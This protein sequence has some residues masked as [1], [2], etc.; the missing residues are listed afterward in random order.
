M[1]QSVSTPYY[2]FKYL[3]VNEGLISN[4][5]NYT[6]K[7]SRGFLWIGTDRGVQRYNGSSFLT[8]RHLHKDSTSLPD[9]NVYFIM[10]DHHHD[11]WMGTLKGISKFSYKNGRFSNYLYAL[12]GKV[13]APINDMFWLLEDSQGRLWAGAR[14]GLYLFDSNKNQFVNIPPVNIPGMNDDHFIRVGCIK[15]TQKQELV[16]T[17]VDG[18]VIMDKQGKQQYFPVPEP[19]AKPINHLP[20][21]Q[22]Y[23]LKDYPDEVWVG[24]NLNGLFKYQRNTKQWTNYRSGGVQNND[25]IYGCLEWDKDTWL[26]GGDF[27]CYFNHRT[28]KFFNGF[29]REKIKY[30]H[31]FCREAN[32]DIWFPS[33]GKGLALFSPSTQLFAKTQMI[34]GFYPDKIFYFDKDLQALYGMNIYFSSGI[35]KLQLSNNVVSRDSIVRFKP[36][37]NVLNN[38]MAANDILYLAMEKGFWQYNLRNQRLDSIVL[39]HEGFSSQQAFFFNTCKSDNKVY[40]TGRF[41][42]GG[43]FVYN[44]ETRAF[45]DL[46][47]PTSQNELSNTYQYQ[48]AYSPTPTTAHGHIN[49]K[50]LHLVYGKSNEPPLYSYSVTINDA[51][52]YVGMNTADSLYTYN[53][54]T[55]HK[56]AIAFPNKY[57]N[58]KPCSVLSLCVDKYQH[59]WCGTSGN[60]VLVYNIATGKWIKQIT[61][62]DGYFPTLTSQI[63]SDE[64]GNIWCNTTEG[65]FLFNTQ[66]FRFKRYGIGEGLVSE[67]SSGILQVLPGHQLLFNNVDKNPYLHTFGIINT[68]PADTI[69]QK[70]PISIANLKVL[71][72]P[73]LTDTLLDNVQHITLP[74]LHNSFSLNYAGVSLPEGKNLLYSYQLE[75]AEKQWHQ[76][77]TEHALSYINLTPGGYTLRI[78]CNN[79]NQSIQG[80]ERILLISILPAWYQTWWFR[81]LVMAIA[82]GFL[83]A[84][85]RY[86]L[87]QQLRKQQIIL[88]KE[89][90][91]EAERQR[92]AADMHDDIG[93]GLSRI[94]YITAAMKE[95]KQMSHEEMDRILSLSDESVEKMNEII[96][97]L[98]QGNRSLE[99]TLA[100]L[101]SQCAE[102]VL[103]SNIE[104]VSHMPEVIPATVLSWTQTRNIYLLAKEAVNNAVKHAAATSIQLYVEIANNQLQLTI[105]DN[106]KGFDHAALHNGNGL[107]G[108][109]K[110]VQTLKGSFEIKASQPTGTIVVFNIPL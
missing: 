101:R 88:E 60:G 41:G 31:S 1:A 47:L 18:F 12:K 81:L 84:S 89:L 13:H 77:G 37:V 59:L 6:Y 45:T 65:L 68:K 5:V 35:A 110:R 16:F 25:F 10:E 76:V 75:G 79:R 80:R 109:A 44:I 26:F 43:P 40:V 52:L 86:Y 33:H 11:I 63:V 9:D 106:G 62:E 8:F 14:T 94:R 66:N 38:F 73:F 23:L 93:A 50:D 92:I 4:H 108:F 95:G 2:Q 57:T 99:D 100:H 7:D 48:P 74:P 64:D 103:Q 87:R 42:K 46:A 102:M 71:G 20:V 17:V 49:T 85:I 28:G 69:V 3:T 56:K 61:Q 53:E 72:Q 67:N 34:P 29:E 27:T 19:T 22:V 15:E 96:W 32:G 36:Y 51:V 24:A 55:G 98:N 91:L 83:F 58:G 70:I 97:S 82:A 21:N 78:R 39:M 90:A 104:F 30:V 107:K 105:T 54:Q